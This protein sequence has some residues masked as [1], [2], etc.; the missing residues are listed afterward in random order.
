MCES[1]LS[2]QGMAYSPVYKSGE[3]CNIM[4]YRPISLLSC[5][6]NVFE[7]L[8]YNSI[9][10]HISQK[11]LKSQ[12]GFL[13]GRSTVQQLLTFYHTTSGAISH[14]NQFDTIY[15]DIK[16]A[17]DSVDHKTLLNKLSDFGISGKAWMFFEAYLSDRLQCVTI[18]NCLSQVLPVTSG[19]L[20]GSILGPLLFVIYISDLPDSIK[21]SQ[22]FI[23]ADDTK[24]GKTISRCDSSGGALQDDIDA[25]FQWSLE[26]SLQL[27]EGKTF[28]TQ[29]HSSKCEPINTLYYLNSN[30]ISIKECCKD[31]GVLVSS[32]H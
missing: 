16:K 15:F 2:A 25:I 18:D 24:C 12:F 6:S 26:N 20:Q 23:Y 10:G 14:K 17:F 4:N 28:T 3:K 22:T 13:R 1:V 9:Y 11:V 7:D 30:P 31:L 5:V 19:V 29:F 27:H 32:S 21:D 8:V